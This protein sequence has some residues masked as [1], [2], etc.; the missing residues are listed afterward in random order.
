MGSWQIWKWKYFIH[1]AGRAF[2]EVA[3][4]PSA[5]VEILGHVRFAIQIMWAKLTKKELKN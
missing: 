4:T 2:V 1:V 5:S 3:F